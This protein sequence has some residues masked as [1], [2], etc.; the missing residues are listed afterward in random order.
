M[1]GA[2]A[3]IALFCFKFFVLYAA[4]N[5][6]EDRAEQY[7]IYGGVMTNTIIHSFLIFMITWSLLATYFTDPGY[8]NNFFTA[9][10]LNHDDE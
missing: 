9:V 3:L 1:L 8:V 4:W 5:L 6:T 7:D 10:E 2:L